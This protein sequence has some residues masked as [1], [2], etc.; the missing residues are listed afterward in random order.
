MDKLAELFDDA[1]RRG[2]MLPELRPSFAVTPKVLRRTY[3]CSNL[4]MAALSV[5]IRA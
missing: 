1:L 4:I 2:D 5:R 3:A